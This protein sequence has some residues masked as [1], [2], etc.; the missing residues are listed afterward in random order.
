MP[1][2]SLGPTVY[3]KAMNKSQAKCAASCRGSGYQYYL[4]KIDDNDPY[5]TGLRNGTCDTMFW[6][7]FNTLKQKT[8]V[9]FTVHLEKDPKVFNHTMCYEQNRGI[10][11]TGNTTNCQQTLIREEGAPVNHSGV[12]NGTYWVQG[13]AW[14]CGNNSYFVLP[15]PPPAGMVSLHPFS[16]QTTQF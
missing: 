10:I 6:V 9:Q 13:V 7:D 4:L 2:H 5:T 1:T 11:L 14:L 12:S 16:Y 3:A 15:P 8:T